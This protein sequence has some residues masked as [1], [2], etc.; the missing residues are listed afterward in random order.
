[1]QQTR[2]NTR[3]DFGSR[4]FHQ[5]RK[6]KKDLSIR[7]AALESKLDLR[8]VSQITNPLY[9]PNNTGQWNQTPFTSFKMDRPCFDWSD[10]IFKITQLFSFHNTKEDQR[11]SIASFY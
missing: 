5:D 3:V 6:D 9:V 7:L 8:P 10:W 11:I 1:M 4:Q 2:S